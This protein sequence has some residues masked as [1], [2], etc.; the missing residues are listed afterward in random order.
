MDAMHD[1]LTAS[2]AHGTRRLLLIVGAVAALLILGVAIAE[3][4]LKST[5]EQVISARTG[6]QVRIGGDLQAHL[7]SA[8]PGVS[9]REV[10]VANPA[11]MPP[12]VTAEAGRVVVLLE[13][14]WSLPPLQIRRLEIEGAQLHL[15]RDAQGRAN[16]LLH[17]EGPGG[18]PPLVHGLSV[19]GAR[20]E[21]HDALGRLEFTGMV[22]AGDGTPED[23]GA[24]LRVEGA[25]QLNGRSASFL[26]LADPL[27][28]LR[29]GQPYHFRLEERSGAT[30]LHGQGYLEQ[31]FD[32]RR[33]QGSFEIRG[34]DLGEMYYLVGLKLPHTAEFE[35]SAK[36]ARSGARFTYTDLH[37]TSGQSDIAGSVSAERSGGRGRFEAQLTATRLRLADLRVTAEQSAA[38]TE[39]PSQT[40]LRIPDTPLMVAGLQKN[41][42]VVK[43]HIRELDLGR[44]I[45]SDA[46]AR[47]AIENAVLSITDVQAGFA[48]GALTGSARLDAGHA[49]PRGS[50]DVVLTGAQLERLKRNPEALGALGGSLSARAQLNGTGT[51]W[52]GMA[53]TAEGT[54]TAVIPRGTVRAALAEAASLELAGALGLMTKSQKETAVRCAVASFSAHEGVL[55]T[56]TVVVDTDKA[57]IT[58]SGDL[59]IDTEALN[60][61]LRGHPKSPALALHSGVAVGGTLA[62]PQFKLAGEGT[63][64]QSGVAV[65]LG[66]TLTPVAALVAFVNPGLA[67]NADCAVLLSG[68]PA[69][70]SSGAG[71]LPAAK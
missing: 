60:F 55:S 51:S 68:V 47:V 71:T 59:Q 24:P 30:H 4:H 8:H 45:L 36:V 53:M 38:G 26:V 54:V 61:I 37:A 42:A 58:A 21:L 10:S 32:F 19:P 6:R 13:W 25:G 41:D 27:A 11:W 5:F 28:G 35:L 23:A 39:A 69:G 2:R 15:V 40:L 70:P 17:E 12:G 64:T 62:H 20:V 3:R 46:S 67:H 16:W 22:S 56:H 43:V 7:F 29:R 66:V 34:P 57:L 44:V 18:G 49:V 9:A 31:A 48:G 33:L 14:H 52:R 63:A 1:P 50:L 65:A